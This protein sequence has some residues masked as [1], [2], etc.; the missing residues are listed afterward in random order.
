MAESRE[1]GEARRRL[2]TGEVLYASR[3]GLAAVDEGLALLEDVVEL[4]SAHEARTARNLAAAYA[5]RLYERVAATLA[6]DRAVPEPMLELFFKLVL[7]FDRFAA[8]LPAN[9]RALKIDVVRHLIDR[10]CEG[11]PPEKKRA[12]LEQLEQFE[13][14]ELLDRRETGR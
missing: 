6:A 3:E 9:A 7:A 14:L 1:L 4:G 12:M 8:G 13:Q 2:A 5:A 10:Y 11:H